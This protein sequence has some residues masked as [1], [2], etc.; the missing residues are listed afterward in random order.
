MGAGRSGPDD[1]ELGRRIGH[2]RRRRK[3]SQAV[4]ADRLGRSKSW[5]EKVERGVRSAGR[6]AVLQDICGVLQIDL[7]ALIGADPARRGADCLDDTGVD[8]IRSALERYPLSPGGPAG[9][10]LQ[11]VRRQLDHVWAAFEFGDYQQ[12]GVVLPELLAGAQ[13]VHAELDSAESAR[14]LAEA[15]QVIAST[16]R[17]LG[18]Y[19]LAWLAGDRGISAARQTGD[20]ALVAA[21]G[22]RVANA[23][24]SMG[25]PAQAL[26]LHMSFADQLQPECRTE[27]ARALYGHLFL[28]AAM[29]AAGLGDQGKADDL[30]DEASGVARFVRPG[31]NHYR[32][33][34]GPVNVILHEV[35]SLV[36]VGENGRAVEVADAIGEEGLRMLRKERRATLLVDTARACSQAGRRDEAL[37]RLL[38]AEQIAPSEV[39]CRPVSQVIIAD[40]LRRSQSAPP[41]AL[42]SLADRA[43]VRA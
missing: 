10:G 25:R 20:V 36:A 5:V 27:P 4:F 29:A 16:L 12:M 9:A 42:T 40:L 21:S 34:F 13:Q 2:W 30:L 22:Y 37:R 15:Y 26:A 19:P 38:A 24:L 18:E 3:L 39:R 1:R 41:P 7:Y 31:S 14:L 23:L 17:K 32:L 11:G 8:R 35:H 28:Q 33:A 6:L 43:R